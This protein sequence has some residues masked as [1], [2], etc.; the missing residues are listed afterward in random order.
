MNIE[1][2][3]KLDLVFL[4]RQAALIVADDTEA[5]LP[6]LV[7]LAERALAVG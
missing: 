6:R 3:T 5:S 1:K 2:Q 4:T 7:L